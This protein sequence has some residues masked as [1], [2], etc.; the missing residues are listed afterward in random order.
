MLQTMTVLL[1]V[2]RLESIHE[3]REP[4]PALGLKLPSSFREKLP[5]GALLLTP[6]AH[7]LIVGP[8]AKDGPR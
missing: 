7:L 6:L 8:A 3:S 1:N 2:T 4:L 5:D